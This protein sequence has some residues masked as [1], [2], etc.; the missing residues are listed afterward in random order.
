MKTR[1]LFWLMSVIIS[2][3]VT[4]QVNITVQ[5]PPV[6]IV[7]NSQLWNITL[8]NTDNNPLFVNIILTLLSTNT[9]Q[10]VFTASTQPFALA[11]GV[12]QLNES[13]LNPIQYTYLQGSNSN[14]LLPI[15]N[16]TACY[17]VNKVYNERYI[18]IAED[19]QPLEV[20]PLSPPMLN[21]PENGAVIETLYP[22]FTWLPPTPLNLFTKL[23]YDLVVTEV[24]PG[25][26]FIQ[27][28]QQN[29]PVYNIGNCT[30]LFDNYPASRKSLD[31]GKIYAWR[32]IARNNRQFVAQ[33]DVWTFKVKYPEQDSLVTE[34]NGY[35]KMKR[36]YEP[37]VAVVTDLLK[38][39]YP[40]YDNDA[41]ATCIL[42]SLGDPGN[43]LSSYKLPVKPGLNYIEISLKTGSK[44][45]ENKT[46][47]LELRSSAGNEWSIK[48]LYKKG[49]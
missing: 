20:A 43:I 29:I 40:N 32:I 34:N 22:Q 38:V 15:G 6:G 19:C 16:Y 30:N 33:S 23:T 17:T 27:A 46:Y 14:G 5:L 11:K 13:R 24:M 26:N 18:Q 2:G 35:L 36:G 49:K 44:L 12:V 9:N 31:T 1:L 48:F 3:A 21:T 42:K 7:Q 41:T 25:Q 10:P 37:G 4:A 45:L 39:E 47:L 28:V 8:S